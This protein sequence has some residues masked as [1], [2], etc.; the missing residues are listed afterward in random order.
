[1]LNQSF[2]NCNI[3]ELSH[4]STPSDTFDE[5]SQV[6]LDVISDTMASIVE[7]GKYVAINIPDT[8]TNGFYVIMLTSKVYTIQENTTIDGK[9]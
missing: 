2:N 9:L 5:I 4:K 6:V 1:M 3:I 7:L 8:T